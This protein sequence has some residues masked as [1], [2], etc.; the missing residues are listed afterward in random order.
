M[1]WGD[2]FHGGSTKLNYIGQKG[3]LLHAFNEQ[4]K[5]YATGYK[6]NAKTALKLREEFLYK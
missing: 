1:S 2:A 5:K 6:K 3:I 4:D